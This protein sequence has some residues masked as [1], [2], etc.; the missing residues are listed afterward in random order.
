MSEKPVIDKEEVIR[1]TKEIL[2]GGPAFPLSGTDK[3]GVNCYRSGMTLLQYYAGCALT[4]M[5]SNPN[6]EAY[7]V[8]FCRDRAEQLVKE[9]TK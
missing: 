5:L 8:E 9:M 7:D 6:L 2:D 1:Q 3:F 4:G